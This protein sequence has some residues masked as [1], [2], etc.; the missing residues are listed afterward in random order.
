MT[1]VE[2][3][4][5]VYE[6]SVKRLWCHPDM[7]DRLLFEFT[8]DY[9]VFDWG[10]MPDRIANKGRALAAIGAYLFQILSPGQFW[11]G[12]PQSPCLRHFDRGWLSD[13]FA[14]SSYAGLV[15]SGLPS[16][17]QSLLNGDLTPVSFEAAGQCERVYM[18]V[19]RAAVGRPTAGV[20]LK[21]TLFWYPPC[22]RPPRLIPL[23]VVFRFGMPQGSSLTSRLAASPDYARQLGLEEVPAAG[24]FF[25]RPV[26]ELYTKLEPADR[27]LSYQE[28][29][30]LSGLSLGQFAELVDLT[31]A[32]ALA[33]FAIL[34]ER[35]LELW[36]G[37]LEFIEDGDGIRL[38]DS[39]GPDELRLV[40]R[41][42]SLSKEMIRQFYRG[43]AW[44][45][46]LREAQKIARDE[47]SLDW[48][49]ICRDRL[50]QEP[51]ALAGERKWLADR[52]YGVL[53]NCIAGREIFAS[54][55]SLD[56]FVDRLEKQVGE[57]KA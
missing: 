4:V 36:D 8:D 39:I 26:L 32:V 29:L 19:K 10:K 50:G 13:F 40:S 35:G 7:P 9:S 23:E 51:E 22:P 57:V 21:N 41:G 2:K 30:V 12:L 45:K 5:P 55:P 28:A 38:A 25:R 11:R 15:E 3:L 37:K 20:V 16:H 24:A 54:Q 52:L 31:F 53:A 17:F 47:A 43:S 33:L 46:G 6:G 34:G 14:G 1:E 18:S 44:E 42:M 49:G 48:K 27:L 56:Q